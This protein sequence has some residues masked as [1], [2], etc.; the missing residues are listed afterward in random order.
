VGALGFLVLELAEIH[1]PADRWFGQRRDL[2]EI[3]FCFIGKRQ[4]LADR[5]DADLL[6]ILADQA[7]LGGSDFVVDALGL[8]LSDGAISS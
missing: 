2:D 4:G 1:D 5:H 3:E 6:A 7:D 8:I